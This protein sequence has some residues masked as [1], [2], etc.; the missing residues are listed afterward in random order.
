MVFRILHY[1][2]REWVGQRLWNMARTKVTNFF[3]RQFV[4][5]FIQT[6]AD[7]AAEPMP[8]N[9][10]SRGNLIQ[11]SPEVA[12]FDGLFFLGFPTPGFPGGPPQHHAIAPVFPIRITLDFT[13]FF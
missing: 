6:M 13:R 11:F 9:P 2:F 12:V 5:A 8:L 7:M 3:G 1:K 4:A 10:V